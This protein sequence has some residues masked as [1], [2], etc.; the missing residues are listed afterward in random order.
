MIKAA[1]VKTIFVPHFE[2][3]SS[4]T[5]LSHA[6]N[7]PAVGLALPMEPREVEKLPR[8]YLANLIYTCVGDPFKTWVDEEIAKR[9]NKLVQEQN[10]TIDMDPEVAAAFMASQHVSVQTGCSGQL[11]KVS[12]H[13]IF[14]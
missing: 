14:S 9:N 13:A 12:K 1:A 2:G 6:R 3:L 5:M 10:L 4:A 7:W 11:M 8:A